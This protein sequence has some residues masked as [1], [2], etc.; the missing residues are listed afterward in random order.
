MN[1]YLNGIKNAD[2]QILREIYQNNF[3]VLKRFILNNNGDESEAKDV[4]QDSLTSI[5]RRLQKED[6]EIETTFRTYF[7]NVGKFIWFKRLK[8]KHP[9]A[10]IEKVQITAPPIDDDKVIKRKIYES[11]MQ[12]LG[13]DCQKVLNFYFEKISFKVIASKMNYTSEEYARRKKYLCVKS[14]TQF[15]KQDPRFN[16]LS[17]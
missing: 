4:F 14:L 15:V 12:K 1:K 5:F 3:L 10:S 9:T 6:F 8:K 17:K 16:E 13:T 2:N 7:F 11:A